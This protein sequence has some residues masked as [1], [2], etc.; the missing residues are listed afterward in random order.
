MTTIT[1]NTTPTI[2]M[3]PETL[4]GSRFSMTILNHLLT[5]GD[6]LADLCMRTGMSV[7]DLA[8][9]MHTGEWTTQEMD[10]ACTAI[11]LDVFEWAR[12]EEPDLLP[13]DSLIRPLP[14][15]DES[16]RVDC[17]DDGA[18]LTTVYSSINRALGVMFRIRLSEVK[19]LYGEFTVTDDYAT[20]TA[21]IQAMN[22]ADYL[23]HGAADWLEECGQRLGAFIRFHTDMLEKDAKDALADD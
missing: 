22:L 17:D 8:D 12:L 18:K 15:A 1:T 7:S 14:R 5:S 20:I 23:R 9:R 3:Q 2:T 21:P 6:T 4:T 19:G 10:A 11:G 16:E 13:T